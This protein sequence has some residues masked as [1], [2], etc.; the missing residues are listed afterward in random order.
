MSALLTRENA[1]IEVNAAADYTAKEG[2]SVTIGETSGEATATV[3]AS[4]TTIAPAIILDADWSSVT[5]TGKA[6][7]A[8]LGA[9]KGTV[10]AKLSGS[11]TVGDR[12]QQAADGTF[13]TDAGSGGRV[14]SLHALESGVSGDLIEV[15]PLPPLA[16][17]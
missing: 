11:V 2:Y 14:V 16:L 8:I 15:A 7:V 10:K 9:A 13:V 12:L 17:S 5:S 1:I 6:R 4:A 3:S